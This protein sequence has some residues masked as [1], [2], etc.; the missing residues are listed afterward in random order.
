VN[1]R[2]YNPASAT[3]YGSPSKSR[4]CLLFDI[5]NMIWKGCAGGGLMVLHY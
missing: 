5:V 1:C 4:F 2:A 3:R